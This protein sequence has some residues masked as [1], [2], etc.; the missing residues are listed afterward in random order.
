MTS[1]IYFENFLLVLYYIRIVKIEGLIDIIKSNLKF[2]EVIIIITTIINLLMFFNKNGW[3]FIWDGKQFQ[4]VYGFPHDACYLFICMQAYCIIAFL[5]CQKNVYKYLVYLYFIFSCFTNARTPFF[6]SI[7]LVLLFAYKTIKNKSIFI[8]MV[9]LLLTIFILLN[10]IYN[11]IDYSDLPIISKFIRGEETGNMTSSRDDI[12]NSILTGYYNYNF[13]G[14][15]FGDGF[16]MSF[17]INTM[18]FGKALWSHNDIYEILVSSGVLGII[19]YLYSFLR[20]I[21][22]SE[23]I[24]FIFVSIIVLFFNG[25]YTYYMFVLGMP[26]ILLAVNRLSQVDFNEKEIL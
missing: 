18:Y 16:G 6:I 26:V 11:F 1:L 8:F 24:I 3:D 7:F 10:K 5:Y 13:W 25:L 14:K 15:I 4:S 2:I 23:N 17:K 9:L 20:T 22:I 21:K 19:I 12:W